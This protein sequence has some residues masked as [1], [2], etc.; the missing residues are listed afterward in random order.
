MRWEENI[1]MR[2][3]RLL[4]WRIVLGGILLVMA[5]S[6][7]LAPRFIPG[8]DELTT[9]VDV[10]AHQWWWEFDYPRLGVRVANV[11]HIPDDGPVRL[12][13]TSADVLHSFWLPSMRLAVDVVPGQKRILV[14]KVGST[15]TLDGSCGAGCGCNTVCMRFRMVI[16]NRLEFQQWIKKQRGVPLNQGNTIAPSCVLARGVDGAKSSPLA[17][18]QAV[19]LAKGNHGPEPPPSPASAP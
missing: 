1:T 6:A 8:G 18:R 10:I 13:L 19:P 16:T 3:D 11:L 12:V 4:K 9:E 7:W 15:G 2:F 14:L 17:K 5:G